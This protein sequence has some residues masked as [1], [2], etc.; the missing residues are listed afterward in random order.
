MQDTML[1][2]PPSLAAIKKL[3][4]VEEGFV[5]YAFEWLGD[6]PEEWSIMKCTGAVF[7]EA[8]SGP[9]KGKKCIKVP[10]TERT[11]FITESEMDA[12]R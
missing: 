9:R 11:V 3:R 5:F 4:S 8:K 10:G 1:N 12:E 7:R 2:Y 6:R